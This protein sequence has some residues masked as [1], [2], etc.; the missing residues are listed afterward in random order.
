MAFGSGSSLATDCWRRRRG[1]PSSVQLLKVGKASRLH[2]HSSKKPT[3]HS[4]LACGHF[5]QSVAP[6]FF[7]SYRG[8]GEVIQRLARCHLTP[9]Q[10]RKRCPDGLARDPPLGEPLLEGNLCRHLKSP[11]ACVVAELPRRAVEQSPSRPRRFRSSKAARVLLGR[12]EPASRASRPLSLKS[13]MASRTVWEPQPKERAIREARS[14]LL[15][16]E[17]D[18]GSAHDESVFGA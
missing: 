13:W 4:G 3:A 14:L 15:T 8:S 5:H 2:Q 18:L 16:G 1:F 9:E 11:E 10:A 12:E 17:D 7:L 6:S